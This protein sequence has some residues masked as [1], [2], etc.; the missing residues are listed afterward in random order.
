LLFDPQTS[1]GLLLA[2]PAESAEDLCSGLIAAGEDAFIIG[3][4]Q[5]GTGNILVVP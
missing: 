1:G 2:V 3:D 5:Q 4:A